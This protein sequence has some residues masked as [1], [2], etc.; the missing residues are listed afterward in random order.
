M[1]KKHHIFLVGLSG[2]GK[3]TVSR[4]L[5]RK[6]KR[7]FVDTDHLIEKK[8]RKSISRIFIEDGEQSFRKLEAETI[9]LSALS[10]R[11]KVF[12]LGGGALNDANTRKLV[13]KSGV[14]VWL[15]SS[16]SELGKRL[17]NKKNRPLLFNTDFGKASRITSLKKTL[18]AMY[19]VRKKH[20]QTSDI[21]INTLKQKP[22]QIALKIIDS[23]SRKYG[24]I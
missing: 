5:A 9:R 8:A 11:P 13:K 3:T 1:S 15:K 21:A 24:T 6:L 10:A 19:Q 22:N 14:S 20:Y 23:I 17:K 12:A 4:I 2:S 18:S 7:Q 16:I